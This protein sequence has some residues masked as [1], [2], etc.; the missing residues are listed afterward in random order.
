MSRGR[1]RP[2][3]TAQ[4]L[5]PAVR[6]D[7]CGGVLWREYFLERSWSP[8]LANYPSSSRSVLVTDSAA[9]LSPIRVAV[10]SRSA[11]DWADG[12]GYC[13]QTRIG[14]AWPLDREAKAACKSAF[15]GAR[16]QLAKTT[17]KP[18]SGSP[19]NT[20]VVVRSPNELTHG[21]LSSQSWSIFVVPPFSPVIG[22]TYSPL[23]L[24]SVVRFISHLRG[25]SPK[26]ILIR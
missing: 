6:R 17:V 3:P 26:F 1:T 15:R 14:S 5:I 18:V 11:N 22:G 19:R 16:A 20:S 7:V 8:S 24:L 2:A 4:L 9:T 12:L 25:N 21:L 10:A 23:S 13:T